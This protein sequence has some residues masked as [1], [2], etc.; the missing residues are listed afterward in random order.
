LPTTSIDTF[1]ACTIIVAAALIGTAFLASTMQ[2]RISDTQDINKQSYLKAIADHIVT[3]Q[4]TPTDWG[5]GNSVPADFGLAVSDSTAPYT[6]D[7]DKISKLNIQNNNSLSYFDLANSAKLSNIAVG[8]TVS[9]ILSVNIQQSSNYTQ[10]S[11]TFLTFYVLTSVDSQ[12]ASANLHC[13]VMA[14]SYQNDVTNST[15]G[16]GTGCLTIEIPSG[17]VDN[18][19]LILFARANYDDRITSYTIYNLCNESQESTPNGSNVVLSP[20]DNTLTIAKNSSS[21]TLDGGYVFSFSYMQS[22]EYNQGASQCQIP[23]LIDK[24]PLVIMVNGTNNG[25]YFEQWTAYPQVP[26]QAGSTFNGSEQNVFS[27]L[28]TINGV[29]Y[30]LNIS[31]G[32]I[33]P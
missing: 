20:L 32:G 2:T 30:R 3:N 31:L 8:I 1:F 17:S 24:S 9:Q 7:P 11:Y 21:V 29:L 14:N 5:K 27:Y 25:V 19:M 26:L 18:A 33:P 22:L 28:V 4:G 10:G 16:V 12:P 15:S 13:Y 6:L 23:G